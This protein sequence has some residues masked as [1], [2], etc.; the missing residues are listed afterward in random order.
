MKKFILIFVLLQAVC[1]NKTFAQI[2][3]VSDSLA[4]LFNADDL[5][6]PVDDERYFPFPEG[7]Y[8]HTQIMNIPETINRN[9]LHKVLIIVKSNLYESLSEEIQRYAYDIHYVYGCNVIMEQVDGETYQDIK[10]LIVSHQNNL[11]GCVFFGDIAPAFYEAY[12]VINHNNLS[13]WPCDFYYM[14]LYGSIW[15]DVN[16]DNILDNYSGNM[17]P[18]IFVGRISTANMGSLISETEGM[19]YFLE[20][21]HKFWIGHMQVNKGLGLAYTNQD[22][23]DYNAFNYNI[24]SLYGNGNYENYR[25][26]NLATFG[27]TDYLNRIN[28]EKYEF[29]QLACHSSCYYHSSFNGSTIYGHEIFSNGVKS[30]GFNLY[31]CSACRWTSANN[32]N[33][34]LAGD[35]IYSPNSDAL[36]VVG[37]TKVGSMYPFSAFYNSLGQGNTIGQALVDWWQNRTPYVNSSEE[38]CWNFGL[39]IIGDPLVNFYHCTNSTC[40]DQLILDS[41]DSSSSPV[42]YYLTSDRIIVAPTNSF[43]ILNN[44]HCIL[45][46]PN[47]EIKGAFYCPLGCSLEILNEGCMQNCD[48]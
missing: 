5:T 20:K 29:V 16:H 1:F 38:L 39:T 30:L 15:Q 31:C 45:N 23:Q 19:R 43:T 9:T 34:F 32:N 22:W 40:S 3:V 36:A 13:T 44:D 11:D 7:I 4:C 24:S 47:V 28:I 42:S 14:D 48:D 41:Y 21:N 26:N 35:Y 17:K 37:S 25:P 12:D 2:G 8:T 6:P 27:K 46:S 33:G 10:N 18:E